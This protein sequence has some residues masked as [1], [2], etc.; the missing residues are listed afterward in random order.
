MDET[1]KEPTVGMLEAP[2]WRDGMTY[3]EFEKEREYFY[4]HLVEYRA[5]T[6]KPL[7]EQG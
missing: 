5:G 1:I 3:A 7:W 4:G 6:Y 2:Y